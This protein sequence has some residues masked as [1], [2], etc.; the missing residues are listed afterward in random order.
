MQAKSNYDYT[1]H[2]DRCP[3]LPIR[4][5]LNDFRQLCQD[6]TSLLIEASTGAGKST[7]LPL[8]LLQSDKKQ[9]DREQTGKNIYVLQPR[10]LAC[11]AVAL[12]MAKIL[13]QE[14]GQTIAWRTGEDH[15]ES[16]ASQIIVM[17]YGVFLRI[18]QSDPGL[19]DCQA[20]FFDE[21]HERSWMSDLCFSFAAECQQ[22][23][24]QDLRLIVMSAT[25]EAKGIEKLFRDLA[26]QRL[27]LEIRNYQ[28]ETSYYAPDTGSGY[29]K[30]SRL[31]LDFVARQALH[32]HRQFG[33]NTLV[34][35]PG[36]AEI[37]ACARILEGLI[38]R[39]ESSIIIVHGSLSAQKQNAALEAKDH[40]CIF[41]ASAVAE[42]SLTLPGIKLVVDCGLSRQAYFDQRLGMDSLVTE[43]VSLAQA[44]QRQGRAGRT[45]D[46]YCWRLWPQDEVLP[47]SH[48][49]ELSRVD[50]S[51]CVLEAASFGSLDYQAM[52]LLSAPKEE[53]W[54]DAQLTLIQLGALDTHAQIRQHGRA[55]TQ[56]GLPVRLAHA[57]IVSKKQSM[58]ALAACLSMAELVAA[59]AQSGPSSNE[60]DIM[61]YW[62]DIFQKGARTGQSLPSAF[63]QQR[64]LADFHKRWK[65]LESLACPMPDADLARQSLAV[66][67][68]ERWAQ[69]TLQ[70][71][72]W[73][74][75]QLSMG[76]LAKLKSRQGP[77]F[78]L[79]VELDLG[80]ST[81]SI[82]RTQT[83][84][85]LNML[86]QLNQTAPWTLELKWTGLS[87]RVSYVRKHGALTLSQT[88]AQGKLQGGDLHVQ[89]CSA[90]FE[91][92]AQTGAEL[93]PWSEQI[94]TLANRLAF[95][96][97]A[98]Q[99]LGII[100]KQT[101][102]LDA[103]N[104]LKPFLK[105]ES[106]RPVLDADSL[107]NALRTMIGYKNL[108]RLKI[109][110][111]EHFALPNGHKKPLYYRLAGEKYQVHL[112]SRVQ[113]FYAITSNPC[114]AGQAIVITLLS[115]AQRPVQITSD[116]LGFWQGTWQQVRKDL[117]G[118]YPKHHWPE[119]PLH[120]N[121]Q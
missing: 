73:A 70:E 54:Q 75:Y 63:N 41:L 102:V 64:I 121:A 58:A 82:I 33:A 5:Y 84:V 65:R 60:I 52:R 79:A 12:R 80:D 11:R 42:T 15:C 90:F 89:M 16:S 103:E 101:I 100:D 88:S 114:V 39:P 8:A 72:E 93:L 44:K 116:L 26:W 71:R 61:D 45:M 17:T 25:I 83:S 21:F 59:F 50:L 94:D 10:R 96:R 98:G 35:L 53:L 43:R 109:L 66:M 110:A 30:N 119:D 107:L 37:N 74:Y 19:K 24:R 113:D 1:F 111:P 91:R 67:F 28:I 49:P 27:S 18:I 48:I 104:I 13:G 23:L 31:F 6:F 86:E 9:P 68:P 7:I 20:V 47:A 46:G 117:R 95:A 2:P 56:L 97:Q 22:A 55:M 77:D 36:M 81:H 92:L 87:P 57:V 62:S 40:G 38:D 3:D 51:A 34:F 69:K 78:L 112:E 115:P 105:L 76:R 99:D 108:E 29:W 118:R 120:S 106:M 4:A 32:G 85:N 14:A